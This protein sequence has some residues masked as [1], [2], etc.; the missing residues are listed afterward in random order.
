MVDRDT[1]SRP[2]PEDGWRPG[3]RELREKEIAG[4]RRAQRVQAITAFAAFIAAM[5]AGFASWQ[6]GQAVKIAQEGVRRQAD[7]TRL[8]TAVGSIGGNL[9]AERV[10][11]FTLLRR[12]VIGMVDRADVEDSGTAERRDALDLYKSSLDIFENYLKNPA[13]AASDEGDRA[14]AP[15]AGL[16]F[17]HPFR[18]SDSVYA[19][20]ELNQLLDKSRALRRIGEGQV[21]PAIDLS[22]TQL[23]G[24]PWKEIDFSW[25]AG[26]YAFRVDLRG[27]NLTYSQWGS[28]SLPEAYLQCADLN[29]ADF[30]GTNLE[31]ADL[32]GANI[33]GADFTDAN[34]EDAK[35]EGVFGL[36]SAVGLDQD[37]GLAL[38]PDD[39]LGDS[40]DRGACLDEEAYWDLPEKKQPSRSKETSR[41]GGTAS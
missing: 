5:A 19:A 30:S 8:S 20:N 28:S 40:Y 18:P 21:M 38:P 15:P 1:V 25:L 11:G 6:A 36:E 26:N 22:T 31:G 3:E 32:R 17:G 16:G 24:Q 33:A 7:E 9:S 39:K 14:Q 12:H 34:L 27:A 29:Q 37:V 10:A 13:S 2:N 4:Q 41:K 35:L 23:Y